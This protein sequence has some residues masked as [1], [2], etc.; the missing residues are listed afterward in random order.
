MPGRVSVAATRNN[1]NHR[2]LVAIDGQTSVY[3]LRHDDLHLLPNNGC[4]TCGIG[5]GRGTLRDTKFFAN[6]NGAIKGAINKARL[7]W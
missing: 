3:S 4:F 2:L 6:E 5:V 1:E 7:T